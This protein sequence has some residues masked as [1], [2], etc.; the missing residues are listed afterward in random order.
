MLPAI[1]KTI[2]KSSLRNHVFLP[3]ER[4]RRFSIAEYHKMGEVGI[5][6]E[7]ERVEL[8]DGVITKMA[9]IGSKHA[10][11]VK[12]LNRIFSSVL[13]LED[14]TIGVQDPII[15]D[16]GTE[17]EPDIALLK[18]R[19]DAYASG[20]PRPSD[21]L[22]IVEVADTSVDDDRAVKL[23]H[24]AAAGIPE[25]WLVNIPD[26]KIEV[27]KMPMGAET[28]AGYKIRVEYRLGETVNLEAFPNVKISVAGVLL[29][30]S[31]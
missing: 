22:L 23:P 15:L 28:D 6:E 25:V 7:D 17:P 26:Q 21:V 1:E 20:H 11:C 19:D 9:P 13:S 31:V 10:A 8:I 3:A 14:A 5:L 4:L 18:P 30:Q 29:M 27:H 24:Y 2:P 16:D 12:K